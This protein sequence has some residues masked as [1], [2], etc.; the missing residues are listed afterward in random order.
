MK[1]N[2]KNFKDLIRKATLNLSIDSVQLDVTNDKIESRMVTAHSDGVV[3]LEVEND[4]ITEMTANDDF[5]LNFSEP[6]LNLIPFLNLID[7]DEANLFVHENRITMT[8]GR[9]RS[10]V[11]FCSPTVV[12]IFSAGTPL[13]SVDYF[14]ETSIDENLVEAFKKIRK[15][16]TK[17]GRVYFNVEGNT[18]S[19]EATDK[20]NTVSNTLKFDLLDDV[21]HVDMS[22]CF[23]YN[24]FQRLMSLI[25]DDYESF[26]FK[27]A[28]IEQQELGMLYIRRSDGSE[29][30][31]L[32][33][34]VE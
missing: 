33:S 29:N 24:N 18:L 21:D 31:F 19:I 1:V 12:S 11:F 23:D 14:L 32:M 22:I 27:I 6:N 3:L 13:E 15:V 16:G 34:K 2:V 10:N 25:L 20:R 26:E 30:F 4:V 7:E 17:F 28:Y 5:Q 9:Q 8:V